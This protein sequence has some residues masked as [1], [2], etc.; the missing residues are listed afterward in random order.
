MSPDRRAVLFGLWGTAL[1][2]S[3]AASDRSKENPMFSIGAIA[4]VQY[5]DVPDSPP[6][7]Y[8]GALPKFTAAVQALNRFDL[9]FVVHLGDFIDRDWASYTPVLAAAAQSKH[10]MRFVLGN[11]DFSVA[12]DKKPMVPAQFAMPGRYYAFSQGGWRFIVLDGNDMSTYAWPEG[13]AEDVRSRALRAARYPDAKP[14]NG[15]IGEAQLS[16]LETELAAADVAGTPVALMCHFPVWPENDPSIL[17]WNA[18]EVVARIETHPSVKLW[19]NGHEHEGGYGV[20]EGIHYLNLKGL[21]DTEE[22]AYAVIDFHPGK[23]EVRG[24]GR[25]PSRSLVLR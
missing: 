25:E 13:S 1:A 17:L 23:L 22:T 20:R 14:W 15:G 3:A 21:L 4:D 6:R 5:A 18:A 24:F 8:R 16:W 7:L 12:N 11:H 19:L 9:A 2:A 10:P